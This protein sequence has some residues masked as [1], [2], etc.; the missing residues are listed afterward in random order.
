MR[1]LRCI[2][3]TALLT[4]GIDAR[5]QAQQRAVSARPDASTVF[6]SADVEP[7]LLRVS[8]LVS[9]GFSAA[10]AR[11][12]AERIVRIPVH[13][14]RTFV[15]QVTVRGERTQLRIVAGMGGV[16]SPDLVFF[17]EPGLESEIDREIGAYF[18]AAG[19]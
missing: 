14:E 15:Y 17:T 12:L 3:V 10:D 2:L 16:A 5:A 1:A 8:R 4:L 11:A 19:K 13:A 9:S 7:V 6:H 18:A